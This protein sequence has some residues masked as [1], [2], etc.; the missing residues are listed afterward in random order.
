M[1]ELFYTYID[2]PVG[3]LLLAG[4]GEALHR[5]GFPR[6]KAAQEPASD[7]LRRNG[8]FQDAIAQLKAYFA[9]ELHEFDLPLAPAGTAF[10]Q[11]TWKALLDIPYGETRSYGEIA[12]Q[13]GKP[14]ASRAV[15]AANGVNP[16]PIVIPCHR[17]I[18]SS[19]HLVGFGG[20]LAA[21]ERLLVLEQRHVPFMLR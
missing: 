12:R 4:D 5:I 18:G 20:G 6:Q 17:V 8:M 10:Q 7:W 3:R 21:K 16:L 2:S 14:T 11:R 1:S 19:G 15:G 9:G 13:I